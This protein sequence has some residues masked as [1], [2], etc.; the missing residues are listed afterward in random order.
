MALSDEEL[1]LLQQMEAALEAE[2]PRLASTMR[3]TTNRTLHRR[4]AALAGFVFL[5]GVSALV[6]GMEIHVSVSIGGFV[7]MLIATILA[8]TSWQH[9]DGEPDEGQVPK[10]GVESEFLNRLEE[11]WRGNDDSI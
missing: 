4:R 3:G 11:R 9:V 2:D 5:V 10:S 8:L 1:R 7:V 6:V